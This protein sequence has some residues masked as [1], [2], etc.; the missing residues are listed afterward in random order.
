MKKTC[1]VCKKTFESGRDKERAP[2]AKTCSKECEKL[3]QKELQKQWSIRNPQKVKTGNRRRANRYY[4]EHKEDYKKK[5]EELRLET[6]IHYSNN[7]PTCTC[8]GESHIEFLEIDHIHGG[9][10]KQRQKTHRH[11]YQWLK[12][13]NYPEGYRVLCAN[14]NKSFGQY[15]YCPHSL[16]KVIG[17]Q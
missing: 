1:I 17:S 13:N 7:P 4:K 3:H 5:R 12:Q 2:S 6:L 8:C 10:T 14:C 9:G 11:F 16:M 15:G